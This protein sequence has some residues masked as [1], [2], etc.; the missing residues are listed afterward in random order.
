MLLDVGPPGRAICQQGG[1]VGE[2]SGVHQ[3]L[4]CNKSISQEIFMIGRP[5]NLLLH[6]SFTEHKKH[7]I[8]TRK[9]WPT[10]HYQHLINQ[11]NLTSE[12]PDGYYGAGH[13]RKDTRTLIEKL[14]P[15]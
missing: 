1:L 4:H 3:Q 12:R 7:S 6:H 13:Y 2:A 10:I 8:V 15:L 11:R 5:T 9:A 14:L